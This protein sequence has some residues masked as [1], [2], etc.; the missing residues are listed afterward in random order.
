MTKCTKFKGSLLKRVLFF[1]ALSF[2]FVFTAKHVFLEEI[3]VKLYGKISEEIVW[4]CYYLNILIILPIVYV[5]VH[6]M[7]TE[8]EID[9]TFIYVKNERLIR[10]KK[11]TKNIPINS[12]VKFRERIFMIFGLIPI[13]RYY[14]EYNNEKI[15]LSFYTEK[16]I[17]RIE[18]YL[19]ANELNRQRRFKE[20][21]MF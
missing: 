5:F 16:E 17:S 8:I 3:Y 7:N 6:Q 13:K 12:S 1:V 4:L 18:S 21:N 10:R 19:L 9:N 20:M 2:I 15:R 14:I 11:K